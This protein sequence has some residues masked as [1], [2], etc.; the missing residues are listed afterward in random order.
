MY[1][2]GLDA[3]CNKPLK[4]FEIRQADNMGAMDLEHKIMN[5]IGHGK[6]AAVSLIKCLEAIG[7]NSL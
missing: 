6:F 5:K 2:V 3:E 4:F 1:D 7:V